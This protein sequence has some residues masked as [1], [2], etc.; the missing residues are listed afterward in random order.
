MT[1]TSLDN[2]QSCGPSSEEGSQKY[3]HEEVDGKSQ[4]THEQNS[5]SNVELFLMGMGLE[6]SK[7]KW[8]KCFKK[9]K[10]YKYHVAIKI[11]SEDMP[12]SYV[13]FYHSSHNVSTKL[14]GMIEPEKGIKEEIKKTEFWEKL[15]EKLSGQ[16]PDHE[17]LKKYLMKFEE[18]L[19]E[20]IKN[21]KDEMDLRKDLVNKLSNLNYKKKLCKETPPVRYRL[22]SEHEDEEDIHEQEVKTVKISITETDYKRMLKEFEDYQNEYPW[23]TLD[24]LDSCSSYGFIEKKP[25]SNCC[26]KCPCNYFCHGLGMFMYKVAID[27]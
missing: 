18:E 25:P 19:W 8:S 22:A 1:D 5:K 20:Q 15:Q 4:D 2:S 21:N 23:F 6:K 11:T 7:P 16:S 26:T 27:I 12:D 3:H 17:A 9:R 13:S 10:Y 14:E 24:K